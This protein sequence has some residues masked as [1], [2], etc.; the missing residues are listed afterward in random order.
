LHDYDKPQTWADMKAL[1]REQFVSSHDVMTSN[2]SE[3]PLLHDDCTT[4]S[5]DNIELSDDS[6]ITY[7]PQL[8]NKLDIVAS[9]P[10]SCAEIRIF[11]HITSVHD[12]LK[13]LSYLNYLGYI[14]VGVLCNLKNLEEKLYFSADLL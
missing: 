1:M 8:E 7:M 9:N 11:N 2:K 14:E 4:D 6:S 12:E 13:L 5:C 3:L 10:I